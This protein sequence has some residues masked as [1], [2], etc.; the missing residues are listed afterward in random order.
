[1][2]VH[3]HSRGDATHVEAVQKVLHVLVGHGIHAEG[4]LELHHALS[5]CGHHVVVSIA[6]FNQ[7]LREAENK[8]MMDVQ[9]CMS[10]EAMLRN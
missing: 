3:E 5:H 7:S 1:M 10:M 9:Y 2:L 6:D 4:L 8:N